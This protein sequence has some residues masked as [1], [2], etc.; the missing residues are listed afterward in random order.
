MTVCGRREKI[1]ETITTISWDYSIINGKIDFHY[2]IVNPTPGHQEN[3]NKTLY[4]W[5]H[6][7]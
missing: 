3:I 6:Y 7:H 2:N 5:N 4:Y 1:W